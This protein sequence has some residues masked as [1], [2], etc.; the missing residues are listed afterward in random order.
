MRAKKATKSPEP[1]ALGWLGVLRWLRWGKK[2]SGRGKTV[3]SD[4][5]KLRGPPNI[6][7]ALLAKCGRRHGFTTQP[8]KCK[9]LT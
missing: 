3:S 5:T 1:E 6:R 2:R 8:L 9:L 4:D 7:G